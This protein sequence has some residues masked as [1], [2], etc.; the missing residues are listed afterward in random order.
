MIAGL[1]A[2]SFILNIIFADMGCGEGL[3]GQS[4]PGCTVHSF[5]LVALHPHITACDISHVCFQM[6]RIALNV[7]EGPPGR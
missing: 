4:V 2:F 6:M 7:F 3:L 5:D 1:L